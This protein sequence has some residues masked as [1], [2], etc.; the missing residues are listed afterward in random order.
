ME[1]CIVHVWLGDLYTKENKRDDYRASQCGLEDND[2]NKIARKQLIGSW[3]YRKKGTL[4]NNMLL[5]KS[6]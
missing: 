1:H 5:K 6:D 3:S 4:L 2:E